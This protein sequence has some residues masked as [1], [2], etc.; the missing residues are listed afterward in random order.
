MQIAVWQALLGYHLNTGSHING[1]PTTFSGATMITTDHLGYQGTFFI[2]G[3]E[4][5]VEMHSI[6]LPSM[7]VAHAI[8]LIGNLERVITLPRTGVAEIDDNL[9]HI[10]IESANS[11][12]NHTLIRLD[13]PF[14]DDDVFIKACQ[15]TSLTHQGSSH[16]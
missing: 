13:S 9:A 4:I 8:G 16:V 10:K 14:I 2:G 1:W 15:K 6:Q 11:K 7:P 12:K 5:T 3:Q